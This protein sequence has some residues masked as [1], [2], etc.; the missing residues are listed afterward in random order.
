MKKETL[1]IANELF[2]RYKDL[3]PIKEDFIAA[4]NI[5]INAFS[6]ENKLLVCGNGGSASDAEHIV[7]ELIKNFRKMRNLPENLKKSL[8]KYD[9]YEDLANG[10]EK[11]YPAISLVS[12][13][14]FMTA[15][16]NDHNPDFC[17]AQQV[18][19]Y[20]NKDDVLLAI[21]TS[22]NSK[23]CVYAA[24]VA[25]AKELKVISLTGE[26]GGLIKKYSDVAIKV[27]EFETYKI[28]ERH[29]PIYHALCAMVEEELE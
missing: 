1:D 12:Q 28:Q 3:G 29:L 15:Y 21:S 23:N 18:N 8:S 27:P 20:G 10:L 4:I 22:G 5:I 17:F 24:Q 16:N 19:V 13:T 6:N 14:S 9:N 2:D 7:G 25:L 11:G 26:K